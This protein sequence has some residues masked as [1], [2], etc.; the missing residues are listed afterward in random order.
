MAKMTKNRRT[1]ALAAAVLLATV[2][3]VLLFGYVRD[4][5]D[6][7][8]AGTDPV[9]V[10]VAK[11]KI[12][13]GMT[14]VQASAKGLLGRQQLPK[15]AVLDGAVGS[16]DALSG[17]AAVVDIYKGEQIVAERFASPDEG[18]GLLPIPAGQQAMSVE[19]DVPPG[20]AGYIQAGDHVSV[21]AKIDNPEPKTQF[22]LQNVQVLTVGLRSADDGAKKGKGLARD[23]DSIVYTLAVTPAGAEKLA[24]AVLH[25]KV[26]FTLLPPGQKP[27][28]TSGRTARNLFS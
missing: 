6:K 24:Y 3:S 2:A 27:A 15:V 28:G 7:A 22:V 17:K 5:R 14:A 13:A 8:L 21:I 16:V 4:I 19:V 20:V 9:E 11:G 12:P 18:R 23:T 10:L 26:Y 1:G 25:G